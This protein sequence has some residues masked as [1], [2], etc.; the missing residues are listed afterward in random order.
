MES[1]AF[2]G[3]WEK[4]DSNYSVFLNLYP[5]RSDTGEG[6]EFEFYTERAADAFGLESEELKDAL[7]ED[8]EDWRYA[9]KPDQYEQWR[10]DGHE[11]TFRSVEEAE[12]LIKLLS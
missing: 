5:D 11:G 8:V 1:L 10:W 3:R 4:L 9:D 6:V 7:P 12:P 2:H